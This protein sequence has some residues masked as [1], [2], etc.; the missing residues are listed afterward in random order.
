MR[1]AISLSGDVGVTALS[2]SGYIE[3][4]KISYSDVD[5]LEV[6]GTGTRTYTTGGGFMGG[7][8]GLTGALEG[9]AIAGIFNALTRQ[10]TEVRD[11]VVNLKAGERQILMNSFIWEPGFLRVLLAP[12][13]ERIKTARAASRSSLP[14]DG[15][16]ADPDQPTRRRYW[17]GTTWTE[18]T[19]P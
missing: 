3:V 8:F 10:S 6:T 13:F 14:P 9:M 7:G 17:N 11:T 16:Y 4:C 2:N 12:V 1:I 19:A 18:H 5:I 15:W